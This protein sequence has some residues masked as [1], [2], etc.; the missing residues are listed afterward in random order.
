MFKYCALTSLKGKVL[1]FESKLIKCKAHKR[2]D[3]RKCI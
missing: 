1:D 2:F 3:E